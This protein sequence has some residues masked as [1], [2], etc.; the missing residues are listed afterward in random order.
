MFSLRLRWREWGE[1]ETEV[2]CDRK[3]CEGEF[4]GLPLIWREPKRSR[5]TLDTDCDQA[6]EQMARER[7]ARCGRGRQ[8]HFCSFVRPIYPTKGEM[9]G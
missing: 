5:R 1:V 9:R 3:R 6:E 2:G 8:R 7:R 4:D